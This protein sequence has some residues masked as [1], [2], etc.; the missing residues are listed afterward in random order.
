M[1][2][3]SLGGR[4]EIWILYHQLGQYIREVHSLEITIAMGA[5]LG[6][7]H[8]LIDHPEVLYSSLMKLGCNF[9]WDFASIIRNSGR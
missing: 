2:V 5:G 6:M 8:Y 9:Q 1:P 3:G 4:K 7:L